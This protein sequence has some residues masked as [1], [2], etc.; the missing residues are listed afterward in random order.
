MKYI[1]GIVGLLV[2][3]YL[4]S[5]ETV[6]VFGVT[7]HII[8]SEELA[9][10]AGGLL[11]SL[12]QPTCLG[13]AP[14]TFGIL[15]GLALLVTSAFLMVSKAPSHSGHDVR[16]DDPRR[17]FGAVR[18]LEEPSTIAK[19]VAEPKYDR[20]KWGVLKEVDEDILSAVR[21]VEQHGS[22][23]EDE[24][25]ERYLAISDKAY[26]QKIVE[27][28]I[29]KSQEIS[30]K[31]AEEEA[32]RESLM[33]GKLLYDYEASVRENY[34]RDPQFHKVVKSVDHYRGSA[35]EFFGGLIITLES[36]VIILKSK[37]SQRNFRSI[38]EVKN[39]GWL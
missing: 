11:G 31:E 27:T 22:G 38:D 17:E 2:L 15:V 36:G 10:G 35:R 20:K 25:A 6:T 37:N 3:I 26:L 16:F 32:A 12:D 8:G 13:N 5:L 23:L 14:Y 33:D 19:P 21:A 7:C 34:G 29:S 39:S 28:V 30:Q 18:P 4:L 24:L 1:T 9:P